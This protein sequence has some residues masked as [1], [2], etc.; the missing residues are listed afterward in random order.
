MTSKIY[1]PQQKHNLIPSDFALMDQPIYM[2]EK[3]LE[4]LKPEFEQPYMH[5]LQHFLFEEVEQ[6]KTIY[7]P[8]PLIFNAFCQTPFDSVKVVLIGQDPY[9]N[10][11]QAQ[12]L[13]FSVSKEVPPPPSLK[14]IFKELQDD[15]RLPIPK[16]G[17]LTTWAK[18]GV[19]LLNATLTV[20]AHE[21]KSHYGKGWE[22]FTDTVVRILA[23]RKDPLVFILWGQSAKEKCS[24]S[25]MEQNTHHLLLTSAH[26]SPY[27]ASYGF[28]GSKPF[29][30]TNAFLTKVGK[31][32]IDW[33]LPA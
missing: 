24:S 28:F 16:Q 26:P 22:T 8:A 30:K 32:P 21:P 2:E 29:S 15:L 23:K 11:R 14:N 6:N 25:I 5:K 7:P 20:R 17:D 12:G 31:T 1:N 13:S 3:W 19:L 10:P 18:Q 9:H 33:S 27:S 4:V